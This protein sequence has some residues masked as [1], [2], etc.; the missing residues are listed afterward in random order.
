MKYHMIYMYYCHGYLQALHLCQA[1]YQFHF[2]LLILLGNY[3][4]L[5]TLV[6]DIGHNDKVT[7][8]AVPVAMVTTSHC[9]L[10]IYQMY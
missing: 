6:S 1:L 9:R 2:Q 10:A 7:S 3:V 8:L 4:K 5:L